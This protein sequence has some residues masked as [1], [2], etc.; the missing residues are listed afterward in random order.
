MIN[1][2]GK[3][4]IIYLAAL[5]EGEGCFTM[6]KNSPR[7]QINMTDEDVIKNVAEMF[8]VTYRPMKGKIRESHPEWKMCYN[9]TINGEKAISLMMSILPLMSQR[10]QEKIK[11]VIALWKKVPTPSNQKLNSRQ[12]HFIREEFNGKNYKE[13]AL[14]YGVSYAAIWNVVNNRVFKEVGV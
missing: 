10:R 12:A 8:N 5:L 14:K 3:N 1:L 6:S 9:V 13:L 7:I 4:K 2:K 11:E